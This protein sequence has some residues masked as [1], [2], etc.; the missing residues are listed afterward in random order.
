MGSNIVT[1]NRTYGNYYY[2][3][4]IDNGTTRTIKNTAVADMDAGDTAVV[5]TRVAG[6]SSD[7]VDLENGSGYDYFTVTLLV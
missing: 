4:S 6:L 5:T 3:S 1:S 2:S 7:V